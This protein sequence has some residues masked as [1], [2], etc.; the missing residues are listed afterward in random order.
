MVDSLM[1]IRLY[2]GRQLKISCKTGFSYVQFG[3]HACIKSI[4][5][6]QFISSSHIGKTFCRLSPHLYSQAQLTLDHF[7]RLQIPHHKDPNSMQ[8]WN[9]L[10]YLVEYQYRTCDLIRNT[11]MLVG[12]I[13]VTIDIT[14]TKYPRPEEEEKG[15]GL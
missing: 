4:C 9:N 13:Y 3:L 11:E 5:V 14:T 6:L 10:V 15:L 12:T 1:N 8:G 2:C 7:I